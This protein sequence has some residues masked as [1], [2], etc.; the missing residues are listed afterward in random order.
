MEGKFFIARSLFDSWIFADA[1]T[2]KI[3]IW[4]IGKARHKK[5]FIS[6]QIGKGNRVVELKRGQLIYGRKKAADTLCLD[7][8]FIYRK[9]KE[10]E[11]K[12]MIIIK[13][14]SQYSIITI[15]NYDSYQSQKNDREQP[16]NNQRTTN[17]QPTNNQRTG[18]EQAMN[19]NNNVNND[20]NVNKEY[21][22]DNSA[23]KVAS[24]KKSIEERAIQFKK[25]I[26]QCVQEKRPQ[27]NDK[28]LLKQFYEYW[29][30]RGAKARKMRKEKEKTFQIERRLDRWVSNQKNFNKTKDIADTQLNDYKD[31]SDSSNYGF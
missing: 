5:G 12:E 18:N 19:T 25:E 20:S 30:E 8:Q 3:W 2:L 17:E 16:M 31:L 26:W 6:L 21:N 13:S 23:T 22:K 15:C 7:G 9:L 24:S 27:Y 28:V 14:N 4:L 11:K 10:F 29:S 1:S